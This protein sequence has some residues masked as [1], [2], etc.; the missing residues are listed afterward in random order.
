MISVDF[1]PVQA[2]AARQHELH[3]GDGRGKREEAGPVQPDAR[4]AGPVRRQGQAHGDGGERAGRDDHVEGPAP[5]VGLGQHAAEGGA[6][7]RA[8]DDRH[9]E[10][11]AHQAGAVAGEAVEH[12]GVGERHHRR[13]DA[14]LHDAPEHD[15]LQRL[16][17][18]A[19]IGGDGEAGNGEQHHP[20]P[21]EAGDQEAGH[22]GD[23]G[24]R[25]D[26]EG[27]GP[28]DLV[29]SGGEASLHL[30]QEGG[31]DQ[32]RGRVE[33]GRQHDGRHDHDPAD[34]RQFEDVGRVRH[35]GEGGGGGCRRWWRDC[36]RHG[37][38]CTLDRASLD[39]GNAGN[40]FDRARA[41]RSG[42]QPPGCGPVGEE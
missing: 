20:S 12:D 16:R 29:R 6:D 26:V 7:D 9:A 36:G 41:R 35:R 21:A 34:E 24:G 32:E 27:G 10:D 33:R 19:K 8:D 13:A 5:V 3:A 30:R 4:A 25:Q 14:A 39:Y 2:L 38:C 17:L 11:R 18:A 31:G 42:P 23:D 40:E 15:R 1:V 28:G 22:R 37:A